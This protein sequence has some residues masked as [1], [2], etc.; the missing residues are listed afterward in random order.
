[1]HKSLLIPLLLLIILLI[2][3]CSASDPIK[4]DLY[5]EASYIRLAADGGG[6]YW[7]EYNEAT[8]NISPGLS[9]ATFIAPNASSLGGWRLDAIGE[10]LYFGASIEGDYDSTGDIQLQIF[11]EVNVDNSGGLATDEV[12]MQVEL[13]CKEPGE[14]TNTNYTY[15]VS[16]VVG[17]AQQ[18]DLFVA[19]V[20]CTAVPSSIVAF[21]LE[22][23]TV[24]SDIDSII[25]NY[26]K[27]K[28]PAC[29]P[30]LERP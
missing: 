20:D 19:T 23:A 13:W 26:V 18:H 8:V 21:R 15:N 24:S 22:L 9:E 29:T 27:V 5:S 17:Q 4:D 30:A 10:W 6:G 3:S 25:V 12:D 11:F 2:S 28:Y 14:G 7:H 1:M 16:T